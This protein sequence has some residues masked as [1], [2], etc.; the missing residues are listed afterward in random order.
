[1]ASRYAPQTSFSL[2]SMMG[3][4]AL[5]SIIESRRATNFPLKQICF[6]AW[7]PLQRVG[8]LD[9][10]FCPS[11]AIT[12][13]TS[14]GGGRDRGWFTLGT[15]FSRGSGMWTEKPKI[16]VVLRNTEHVWGKSGTRVGP[17]TPGPGFSLHGPAHAILHSNFDVFYFPCTDRSILMR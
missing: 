13:P 5:K 8:S 14:G 6:S 2:I 4:F 9:F 3:I 1:M 15:G 16:K 17:T 12:G 10:F 7:R 11:R